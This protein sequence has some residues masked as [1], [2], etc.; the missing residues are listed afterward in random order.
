MK[1]IRCAHVI[2]TNRIADIFGGGPFGPE[3]KKR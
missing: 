3:G 2:P 1:N